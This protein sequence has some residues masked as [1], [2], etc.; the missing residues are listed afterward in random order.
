MDDSYQALGLPS[1]AGREQI[2][3]AY[4]TLVRRYPPELNPGRFAR[5]Q[6][7][8]DVL[9]S[10]ESAMDEARRKPEAA[11]ATLF[12]APSLTLRPGEPAPRPLRPDDLEPLLRTL[13]RAALERLLREAFAGGEP[14]PRPGPGLYRK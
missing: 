3:R 6:R 12:P 7:A 2:D 11:L 1:G 9:R 13:R 10:L 8:Y 5:I 14:A 4:R